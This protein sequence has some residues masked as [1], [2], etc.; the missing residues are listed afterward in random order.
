[1]TE[2]VIIKEANGS[3]TVNGKGEITAKGE[4]MKLVLEEFVGTEEQ[5]RNVFKDSP[6]LQLLE[7]RIE[8]TDKLHAIEIANELIIC[9]EKNRPNK[10]LLKASKVIQ[11]LLIENEKLKKGK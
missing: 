10:T 6:L 1:M 5:L 9:Y 11:R 8:E 3:L 2:Y 4:F 7:K